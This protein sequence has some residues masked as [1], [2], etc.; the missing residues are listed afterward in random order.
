MANTIDE[1]YLPFS[2]DF[3]RAHLAKADRKLRNGED[4]S[5]DE[6][7][8]GIGYYE[9]SARRYHEFRPEKG[10]PI[11][12]M[13][14]PRQ[15]EKDERFWTAGC[16]L[17]VHGQP[18]A[19]HWRTLLEKCF[20]ARP[21]LSS[22]ASWN[23]LLT[24]NLELRIE[25]PLPSS[26]KYTSWLRANLRERQLIPYVLDAAA[27]ESGARLEGFTHADA[28]LVSEKTGFSVIFEAKVCADISYEI[29]FDMMRNQ[30][31]R[32]IDVM[33][34]PPKEQAPPLARRDPNKTLFVLLTPQMFVRNWRSRLYGHLMHDY[35]EQPE[36]IAEDLPHRAGE[37][38]CKEVSRRLGWITWEECN[39]IL[40]GACSWLSSA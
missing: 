23:D 36:R 26:E 8:K 2:S 25:A 28:I 6:R 35:K 12:K 7:L 24:E 22:P 32:Y 5:E 4:A 38:D 31:A 29:T 37:L 27:G 39:A 13:R 18:D 19:R 40:P 15:I 10:I 16:L 30:I 34:D 20:G 1:K 21:P 11:S 9:D 14:L 17:K 33:L 3:V